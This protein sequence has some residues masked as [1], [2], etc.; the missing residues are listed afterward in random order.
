[1]TDLDKH[2]DD[3]PVGAAPLN[4]IVRAGQRPP[5]QRLRAQGL[6]P[7]L[8]RGMVTATALGSLAA[9]FTLGTAV[10]QHG[11][12]NGPSAGQPATPAAPAGDPSP[13]GFHGELTAASSCAALTQHY[14]G[15]ATDE[16]TAYGWRE[17][18]EWGDVALNRAFAAKTDVSVDA[19]RPSTAQDASGTGTNT[20]EVGV[21]EPDVVK[22][23]GTVLARVRH[24]TVSLFDVSG[25]SPAARGSVRIPG[26]REAELLLSGDTVIAIGQGERSFRAGVERQTRVVSLDISNPD[27]PRVQQTAS[28]DAALLSARA[29]GSVVRLVLAAGLPELDFI[30][31]DATTGRKRARLHNQAMVEQS[32]AQD[33]LPTVTVGSGTPEPLLDCTRVAVPTDDLGLDTVAVVGFDASAPQTRDTVGIATR[34]STVY[35]A[36]DRLF[37]AALPESSWGLGRTLGPAAAGGEDEGRTHLFDF[38]LDGTRASYHGSTSVPGIVKDRWSLDWAHDTLRVAAGRSRATRNHNSVLVL[39]ESPEG[40]EQV[41]RIGKLGIDEDIKAVRWFDDLAIVVTFRE[42]DPLY[43]I[44]L[45][46]PT[47]PVLRGALKI[48]GFSEYLHPIGDDRL[49]GMGQG[50]VV[51]SGSGA[52]AAL[53]DIADLT[54]PRRLDVVAYRADSWAMP[55]RDPRSF[56]WL[57]RAG[58]AVAVI[59]HAGGTR[60]ELSILRPVADRL[61]SRS[62]KLP[63]GARIDQ[64]RVVPVRGGAVLVAGDVVRGLGLAASGDPAGQP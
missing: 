59:E 64:V 11:D 55:G 33:W 41:A 4:A 61:D 26:L 57:P 39:K 7:A 36:G 20:Q 51:G 53:F 54:K 9:A 63:E 17:E 47:R 24:D 30:T 42:T 56:Q 21:D 58:V 25:T 18:S 28:Y 49:I 32:T 52:Q 19:A 23:D 1:M 50:A 2:W 62:E 13:V 27:A 37:L 48:P 15:A 43:T 34:A 44:D 60:G 22:T 35:E 31:P 29:H 6:R 5:A 45:T 46:D 8:R 16:V 3:L 38:T 10:P 40:L 14:V 12:S